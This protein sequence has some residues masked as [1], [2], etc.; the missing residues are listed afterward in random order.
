MHSNKRPLPRLDA[1]EN[2]Q[3]KIRR[4]FESEITRVI[5]AGRKI[6][7]TEV[8]VAIPAEL[9]EAHFEKVLDLCRSSGLET[10][11]TAIGPRELVLS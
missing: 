7:A 3:K 2:K 4:Q 11:T 6:S 9:D 5:L 8:R 1:Y 10:F